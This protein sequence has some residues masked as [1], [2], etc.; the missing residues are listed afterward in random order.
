MERDAY[1]AEVESYLIPLT[2]VILP[3]SRAQ[4]N[5]QSQF[6][7]TFINPKGRSYLED[8]MFKRVEAMALYIYIWFLVHLWYNQPKVHIDLKNHFV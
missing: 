6:S 1:E 3:P 8:I 4:N 5:W 7:T 2:S